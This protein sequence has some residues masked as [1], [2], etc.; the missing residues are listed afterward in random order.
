MKA[1]GAKIEK[2]PTENPFISIFSILITLLSKGN[3]R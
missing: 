1:Q 3:R 2:M